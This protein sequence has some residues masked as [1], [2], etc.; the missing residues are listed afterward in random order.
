MWPCPRPLGRR[1]ASDIT[2]EFGFERGT[3]VGTKTTNA[4][5]LR[6]AKPLHDLLGPHLAD[7]RHRLEQSRDF[8]LAYDVIRLAILEHLRQRRRAAL[9]AILDL[10]TLFASPGSLLQGGSALLGCEG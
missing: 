10:S 1:S 3:L 7:A 6:D 9:E 2:A 4:P 5:G 8:H